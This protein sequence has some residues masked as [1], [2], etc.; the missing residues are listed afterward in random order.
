MNVL[1]VTVMLA[2]LVQP[3]K[4]PAEVLSNLHISN[5]AIAKGAGCA[6][7]RIAIVN[8]ETVS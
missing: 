1:L 2:M 3:L 5:Q 4:Q 8:S 7:S 6:K